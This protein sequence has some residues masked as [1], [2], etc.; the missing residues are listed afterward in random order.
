MKENLICSSRESEFEHRYYLVF[1]AMDTA[2]RKQAENVQRRVPFD[3]T[4]YIGL[5]FTLNTGVIAGGRFGISC[6]IYFM[7]VIINIHKSC[8]GWC[9]R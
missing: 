3:N 4:S 7:V 8:C 9:F 2:R 5:F 6:T 1:V